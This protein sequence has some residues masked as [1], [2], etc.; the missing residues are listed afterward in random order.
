VNV[1]EDDEPFRDYTGACCIS[2]WDRVVAEF[3]FVL[4]PATVCRTVFLTDR[5]RFFFLL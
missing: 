3:F 4:G 1:A 5:Q 2:L